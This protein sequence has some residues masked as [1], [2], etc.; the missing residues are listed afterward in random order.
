MFS[1]F[2]NFFRGAPT[3]IHQDT[4]TTMVHNWPWTCEALADTLS[5]KQGGQKSQ[6][7]ILNWAIK[8][9]MVNWLLQGIILPGLLGIMITHSRET[10]QPTSIMRWY[11]GIFNG[12]IDLNCNVSLPKKVIKIHFEDYWSIV[13]GDSKANSIKSNKFGEFRF[14]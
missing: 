6:Q 13:W 11:R 4:A 10:Y 14:L 7:G 12:S 8:N 1:M 3:R 9:T 2:N 5:L